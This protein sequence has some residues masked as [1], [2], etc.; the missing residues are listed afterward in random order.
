MWKDLQLLQQDVALGAAVLDSTT[1]LPSFSIFKGICSSQLV[2]VMYFDTSNCQSILDIEP[3]L[4]TASCDLNI[5]CALCRNIH[6][7]FV[8]FRSSK[9]LI[10]V[11]TDVAARGLG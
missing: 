5:H 10:L 9:A 1:I 7:C 6:F 11:A 4:R 8:E 2:I 3:I